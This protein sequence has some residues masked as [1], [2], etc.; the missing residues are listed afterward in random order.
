M[1]DPIAFY[2]PE[3]DLFEVP[4]Q[5]FTDTGKL[6]PLGFYTILNWK[7]SRARTRH[8]TRLREISGSFEAASKEIAEDLVG[9]NGPE[10]RLAILLSK[11]LR[12]F[13]ELADLK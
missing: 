5:T 8:L 9:A 3:A 7:A 4:R 12:E 2:N 13:H 10:E 6:D 1:F 11:W